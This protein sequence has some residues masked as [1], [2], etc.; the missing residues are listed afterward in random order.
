MR[1]WLNNYFDFTK[2]EFN[3]LLVLLVLIGLVTAAPYAYG[4]LKKE[5]YRPE[6]DLII[7]RLILRNTDSIVSPVER[8]KVYQST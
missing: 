6:D 4:L 2:S 1:K 7:K 8:T 3:G 5:E